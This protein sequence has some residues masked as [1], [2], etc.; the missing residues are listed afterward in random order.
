MH[1]V[2]LYPIHLFLVWSSN[3]NIDELQPPSALKPF[4]SQQEQAVSFCEIP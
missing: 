2:S 1:K 4:I 3:G